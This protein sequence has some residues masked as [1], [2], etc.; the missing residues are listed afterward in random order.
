MTFHTASVLAK[1]SKAKQHG[2]HFCP[3]ILRPGT[4]LLNVGCITFQLPVLALLFVG[5]G[6]EFVVKGR[7]GQEGRSLW[8]EL[9]TCWMCSFYLLVKMREAFP[10]IRSQEKKTTQKASDVFSGSWRS[11]GLV[12]EIKK[13][14]ARGT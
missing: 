1:N 14:M 13:C 7:N 9:S 8:T 10:L 6:K 4:R 5:E 2:Y 3:H 12:S 11:Q